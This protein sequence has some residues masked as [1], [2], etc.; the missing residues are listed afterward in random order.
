M[1]TVEQRIYDGNR[2]KEILENEVF[3]QVFNDIES[4][5]WEAWK[6]APLKDVEGREKLHQ[7]LTMLGKVKTQLES[8]LESGKLSELDVNHHRSMAERAKDFLSSNW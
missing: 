8:I 1:P 5:I 3:Q 4:E 2:A 7:Y 6:K